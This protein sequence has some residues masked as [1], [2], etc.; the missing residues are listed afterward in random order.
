M[1]IFLSWSG[2]T[3]HAAANAF[4]TFL[5]EIIQAT[6]PFLSSESIRLGSRWFIS[7][8]QE[9]NDTQFGLAF[10]DRTNQHAPWICFEVG[11]LAKSVSESGVVPILFGMT[12]SKLQPPLSQFQAIEF[13]KESILHLVAEINNRCASPLSQ[14]KLLSAFER[15]WPE[16]NEKVNE[17]LDRHPIPEAQDQMP[18]ES[19]NVQN[20]L[21]LAGDIS[22]RLARIEE[23]QIDAMES[24]GIRGIFANPNDIVT[25][26]SVIIG[27]SAGQTAPVRKNTDKMI[28]NLARRGYRIHDG[29]SA[30]KGELRFDIQ[31]E[32]PYSS[33][34]NRKITECIFDAF[35][36]VHV[37]M[38]AKSIPRI[39]S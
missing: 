24:K 11:A 29:I 36:S 13:S 2:P 18:S 39:F 28:S 21:L 17:A 3:S 16:F 19:E 7:L 23:K 35:G 37:S 1:K 5:P 9:L 26:I 6:R 31:L 22:Q 30:V 14:T 33:E 38:S 34:D 4:N 12:R 32:Q 25:I 8:S 20:L 27:N 15:V 10:V